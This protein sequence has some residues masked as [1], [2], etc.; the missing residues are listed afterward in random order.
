MII[1]LNFDGAIIAEPVAEPTDMSAIEIFATL[2]WSQEPTVNCTVYVPPLND[3][4]KIYPA[5]ADRVGKQHIEGS[6][7]CLVKLNDDYPTEAIVR[8]FQPFVTK[9]KL[10]TTRCGSKVTLN[11]SNKD[12]AYFALYMRKKYLDGEIE[13]SF[14]HFKKKEY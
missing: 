9:G 7:F 1:G 2:D 11:F 12:D 14:N 6:L 3:D 8:A 5:K 13:L 4:I 10:T